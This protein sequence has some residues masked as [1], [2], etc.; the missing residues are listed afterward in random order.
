MEPPPGV[1]ALTRAHLPAVTAGYVKKGAWNKADVLLVELA[2]GSF[3]VK[4]YAAK[5]APVRWAG[6]LQLGRERRAYGRL[7]GVPGIPSYHG[8]LD[9]YA[10]VL[11]YVGGIRLPKYH[12]RHARVPRV[13]E[14]LRAL[15]DA[16]H[17]RGVI[18]GDLR[19]RDNFLVTSTGELYLIDFSSAAVFDLDRWPGR[20]LF[21]RFKRAEDRALLKWKVALVPEELT[22]EELASH[23]RFK[24]LRRLWPLNR[25][26]DLP[27][28]R[29]RNPLL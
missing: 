29:G 27:R 22:P 24:R 11:Q 26:K 10:I 7:A 3:A 14:R 21:P 13:A 9:R 17:A 15:L 2:E 5:S 19:S 12:H 4:D 20:V 28:T 23:R 16:V 18:H 6:A 25:K 1:S 8:A